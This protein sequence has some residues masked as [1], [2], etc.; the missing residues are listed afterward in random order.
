MSSARPSA[1]AFVCIYCGW[2]NYA[3]MAP[4]GYPALRLEPCPGAKPHHNRT[5]ANKCEECKSISTL[6][7]CPGNHPDQK[8]QKGRWP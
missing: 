4:D 1:N 6:Y 2:T 7:W 5:T 8:P 3:D